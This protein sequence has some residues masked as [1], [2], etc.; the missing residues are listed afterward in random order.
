MSETDLKTF[1]AVFRLKNEYGNLTGEHLKV[2]AYSE[3]KC[4]T[5]QV[6]LLA[7]KIKRFI[8]LFK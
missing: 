1:N 6:V 7:A 5:F 8:L 3:R 2:Y 4:T